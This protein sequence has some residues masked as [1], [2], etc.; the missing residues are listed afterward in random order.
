MIDYKKHLG[1]LFRMIFNV[2]EKDSNK[3]FR[4]LNLTSSQ[5]AVMFFLLICPKKEINQKDIEKELGLKNPT[6]TG[7]LKRMEKKGLT[8]STVNPRD[9]RYKNIYLTEK[10]GVIHARLDKHVAYIENLLISGMDSTEVGI[11]RTLL[12]KVLANLTRL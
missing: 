8:Y 4:K 9:N 5:A 10:A 7:I 11:L 1:P 6:V 3:L 12:K 2:F